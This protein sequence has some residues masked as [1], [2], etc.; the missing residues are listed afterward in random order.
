MVRTTIKRFIAW[1]SS[2][3]ILLMMMATLALLI[4]NSPLDKYYVEILSVKLSF[5]LGDWGISKSLLFWV[6]DGFMTLFF[7]LVGLE[8]KREFLEG[9]LSDLKRAVLPVFAAL[10]GV[11]VPAVIY[12]FINKGDLFAMSGWAITAATDIAFALGI[13][14]LLGSRVPNSLKTFLSATAIIDDIGAIII[15]ATFYTAE[16]SLVSLFLASLCVLTLYA[17]NRAKVYTFTPYALV[18]VAMWLCVLKSGVHATLTGI[19]IALFFPIRDHSQENYSPLR[20]IE[21]AIHP[22]VA[23]A[24]LPLFA[25]ANAGVS[26]KGVSLATLVE[27]IPLGIICGLF[28]GKQLGVFSVSW[29]VIKSGIAKLP[30]NVSWTQFYGVALLCGIG[31]TMSLFIGGLAFSGGSIL[32]HVWLRVGVLVGS[33]LSALAGLG[34]LFF[35]GTFARKKLPTG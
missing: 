26:F 16:L 23:F 6:N 10:G 32:Y 29:I 33:L 1:E 15:I 18:G 19:V 22:W 2:A 17:L 20:E 21:Q 12:L 31:F 9:E 24:I 4:S 3:G 14:S 28:L 8:I 5:S 7:L 34:V 13:L 30:L 25:F 27:P 35:Y 11:V